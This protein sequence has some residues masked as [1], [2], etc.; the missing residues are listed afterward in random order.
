MGDREVFKDPGVMFIIEA[1]KSRNNRKKHKKYGFDI[2]KCLECKWLSFR[3]EMMLKFGYLIFSLV[4]AQLPVSGTDVL[5]P[6]R[7]DD[8]PFEPIQLQLNE[9]IIEG[10][11]LEV[12]Y[13]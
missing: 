13:S 12:E 8:Q 10:R 3:T 4:R 9:G 11:R 1:N 6:F 2:Y 5:S 7:V